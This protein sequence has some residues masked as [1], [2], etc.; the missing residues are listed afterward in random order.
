M[1]DVTNPSVTLT[2]DLDAVIQRRIASGRYASRDEVISAALRV[3]ER[4]EEAADR[5]LADLGYRHRARHRR[6]GGRTRDGP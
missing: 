2:P 5:K 1:A 6:R 3:L 4:D